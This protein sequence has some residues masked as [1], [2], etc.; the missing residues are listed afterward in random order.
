MCHYFEWSTRTKS[1][2]KHSPLLSNME[3]RSQFKSFFSPIPGL[4]G[5]LASKKTSANLSVEGFLAC[6]VTVT[7]L[8]MLLWVGNT[9]W[10]SEVLV[11]T[12]WVLPCRADHQCQP[13]SWTCKL[14][15]LSLLCGSSFHWNSTRKHITGKNKDYHSALPAAEDSSSLVSPLDE[16]LSVGA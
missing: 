14:M 10:G 12:S 6:L 16:V 7:E 9:Q 1:E 11:G 2:F 4:A 5:L 8:Q 15:D 13:H 3:W